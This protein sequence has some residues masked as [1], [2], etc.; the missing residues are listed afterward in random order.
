MKKISILILF[1]LNL[2]N[3]FSQN[4][5]SDTLFLKTESIL[6]NI[7]NATAIE[8]DVEGN[9]L[10]LDS[11]KGSIYRLSKESAYQD[12]ISLSGNGLRS[13][14]LMHPQS[15][16]IPNR[17]S[18]YVLDDALGHILLYNTDLRLIDKVD[19]FD[20]NGQQDW[21]NDGLSLTPISFDLGPGGDLFVL[22]QEDNKIYKIN[23]YQELER[24]FGGRDFGVG[25]LFDP[26]EL[27]VDR[28]NNIWV[29][30]TSTQE[31]Y[32]FGGQGEF[33]F[34][35][36]IQTKFSWKH[37]K[38]HEDYLC[39]FG[40]QQV[41]FEGISTGK[42]QLFFTKSPKDIVDIAISSQEIYL[43]MENEIHL[44]RINN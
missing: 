8:V 16:R 3:I 40:R 44:C 22:N 10:L 36:K 18:I 12:V 17:Q 39:V 13:Q 30:D 1:I 29:S 19:F 24:A 42:L 34:K 6:N 43:L 32:C 7:P 4:I 23:R 35:R 41:H 21:L 37:F 11:D 27:R 15:V 14:N 26:V 33:L 28:N 38:I 2:N 31:L 9:I 25:S 20:L 5:I